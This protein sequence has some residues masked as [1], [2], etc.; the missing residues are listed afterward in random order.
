MWDFRWEIFLIQIV[1][2]IL[3]ILDNK[4]KKEQEQILKQLKAGEIDVIIGTHRLVQKDVIFKDL[5]LLII[6]EEQKFGVMDK[7]RIKEMKENVD[8]LST[9][10]LK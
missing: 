9:K 7:E 1:C 4:T 2:E 8:V 3:F 6:D 10:N 5:G